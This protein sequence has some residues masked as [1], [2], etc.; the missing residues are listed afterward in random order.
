MANI[1]DEKLDLLVE[2]LKAMVNRKI[3]DLERR[4][5]TKLEVVGDEIPKVKIELG[6]SIN[7]MEE[8]LRHDIDLTWDYAVNKEQY[9]RKNNIRIL[10]IDE[11]P[12]ENL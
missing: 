6:K 3:E 12:D 4:L 11:E 2:C 8:T 5:Q 7:H 1:L 10:G 9:L